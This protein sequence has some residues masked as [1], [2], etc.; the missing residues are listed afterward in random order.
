[1]RGGQSYGTGSAGIG[2]LS[3]PCSFARARRGRPPQHRRPARAPRPGRAAPRHQPQ[4]DAMNEPTEGWR[5]AA[6]CATAPD[7]DRFVS[8]STPSRDAQ[9]LAAEF[10]ATCPVQQPCRAYARTTRS[11]GVWGGMWFPTPGTGQA[12]NLITNAGVVAADA[13]GGRRGDGRR[14]SGSV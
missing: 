5:L 8:P 6:A 3:R 7:P 12:V 13:P 2:S 10:C 11:E 14:T 1:G 4:G 9:L